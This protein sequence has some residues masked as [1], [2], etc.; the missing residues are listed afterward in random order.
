MNFIERIERTFLKEGV[1]SFR[2]GDTVDVHYRITEGD[3]ERVQ[4]FSGVVIALRG[5]GMRRACIVRRI[6]QGEGVERTFPI[7]SP[8]VGDVVVKRRGRVRRAKLYY[9]RE[10]SGKSTRLA[11]TFEKIER[12]ERSENRPGKPGAA[13]GEGAAPLAAATAGTK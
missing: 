2:V 6:V 13:E 9:L 12:P 11:D 7:H 5:G 10:R 4:L 1:P 8:R 3:R